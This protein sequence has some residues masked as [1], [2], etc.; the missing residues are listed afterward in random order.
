MPTEEQKPSIAIENRKADQYANDGY[1]AMKERYGV[2]DHPERPGSC[3]R[4][5]NEG[6]KAGRLYERQ[7]ANK[8]ELKPGE[9][10]YKGYRIKPGADDDFELGWFDVYFE[11]HHI[12]CCYGIDKAYEW[13]DSKVAAIA[14]IREVDFYA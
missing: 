14:D 5:Y 3:N 2:Q 11:D 1:L 4:S 8:S 7:L 10:D 12:R 9:E 6:F 13:I